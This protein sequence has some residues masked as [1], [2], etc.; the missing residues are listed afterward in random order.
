[1][2]IRSV[3]GTDPEALAGALRGVVD[4]YPTVQVGDRQSFLAA[5][6]PA[7]RVTGR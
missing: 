6:G 3:Q 4:R 5:P 7:A 2:L 1:M